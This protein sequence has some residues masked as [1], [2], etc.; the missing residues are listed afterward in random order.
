MHPAYIIIGTDSKRLIEE[1][2]KLFLDQKFAIY[3]QI[4]PDESPQLFIFPAD[5]REALEKFPTELKQL[6]CELARIIAIVDASEFE[7]LSY[8]DMLAHFADVML[9]TDSHDQLKLAQKRWHDR[10]MSIYRWPEDA[11]L[12]SE[13][14]YPEARRLSQYFDP[15][16]LDEAAEIF[17][18]EEPPERINTHRRPK[19]NV[20]QANLDD[21]E[22][23][24][25]EPYFRR[26]AVGHWAVK[27]KLP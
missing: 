19:T 20:N 23:I 18:E 21:I 27:V 7:E 4:A 26:D 15:D 17:E 24:P 10:P 1:S 6:D 13:I 14:L 11:R 22:A 5:P 16:R 25:D 3:P 2:N 8:C 12:G 9:I